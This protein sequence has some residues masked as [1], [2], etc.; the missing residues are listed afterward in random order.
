MRNHVTTSDRCPEGTGDSCISDDCNNCPGR[1]AY[2]Y[3][4]KII[5]KTEG[6]D[7]AGA[8]VGNEERTTRTGRIYAMPPRKRDP[9]TDP[10]ATLEDFV[11]RINRIG[12]PNAHRLE[13]P[14][15]TVEDIKW[16]AVMTEQLLHMLKSYAYGR[17]DLDPLSRVLQARLSVVS[18][19][20]SMRHRTNN[21]KARQIVRRLPKYD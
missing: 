7:N 21:M 8:V 9:R 15:W 12:F 18:V 13:F 19:A 16:C 4:R 20:H 6:T 5:E 1:V 2:E 11:R 14:I 3:L 17:K 10:K